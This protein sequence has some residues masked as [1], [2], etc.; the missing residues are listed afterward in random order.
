MASKQYDTHKCSMPS[1]RCLN[2]DKSIDLKYTKCLECGYNNERPADL[3]SQVQLPSNKLDDQLDQLLKAKNQ[4]VNHV[5]TLTISN[6][7]CAYVH[8]MSVYILC[9][10]LGIH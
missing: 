4:V 6:L 2:Q 3:I 10:D 1:I 8:F 9:C 5:I 7:T